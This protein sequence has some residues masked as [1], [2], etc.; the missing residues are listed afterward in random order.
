M[1]GKFSRRQVIAATGAGL[2]VSWAPTVSAT[3]EKMREERNKVLG[4][5]PVEKGGITLETPIIAENGGQVP[6]TA[7][8]DS[9]MTEEDH[10]RAIHLFA[11]ENPTPIVGSFFFTPDSG[12]AR[13]GSAR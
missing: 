1:I 12:L 2:A 3:P 4:G 5:K 6:I 11:E 9:P 8:V 13:T 10:V 7:I